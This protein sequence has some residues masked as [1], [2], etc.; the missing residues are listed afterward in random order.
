VNRLQPSNYLQ[1]SYS[2]VQKPFPEKLRHDPKRVDA[3]AL[4]LDLSSKAMPKI[5]FTFDDDPARLE[6]KN[7]VSSTKELLR[8]IAELNRELGLNDRD[9]IRVTF[10]IQGSYAQSKVD[11]LKRIHNEGH[12]LGNHSYSH[13]NFHE[14]TL[15]A[16][17]EDISRTHEL[18]H[19]AIGQEPIYLRPPFGHLSP[20]MKDKIRAKFPNYQFVSWH[21]HYE[22]QN[23]TSQTIQQQMVNGAFDRQVVL[24]HSWK[25]QT[26]Y[27]MRD[28]LKL[29][30][31]QGYQCVTVRELDRLPPPL[32]KDRFGA[33]TT[34]A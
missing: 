26:L 2:L 3:N 23:S 21:K 27:A 19:Q 31:R 6:T 5:A 25:T 11:L 33:W 9:R 18:I 16:I 13:Q 30:H 4:S 29:L 10:F 22:T 34:V 8:V 20:E 24:A 32:F 7:G 17:V 12:E 15:D 28:T 14:L 1:S